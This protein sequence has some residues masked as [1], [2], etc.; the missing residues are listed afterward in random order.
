M[1]SL[2]NACPNHQRS[3]KWEQASALSHSFL[4]A[5]VLLWMLFLLLGSAS[6]FKNHFKLIYNP[7]HT[8]PKDAPGKPSVRPSV[9]RYRISIVNISIL[10]K[11]IDII[12][13]K[14]ILKN[15][16]IAKAIL[17]N[18]DIDIDRKSL[19]NITEIS[20]TNHREIHITQIF[21]R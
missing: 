12:I 10:L 5:M 21:Y 14:A 20:K 19:R 2:S 1:S 18:I 9:T 6:C 4:K 15:I 8:S 11:N 7:V 3:E 13:D 16:D 17:K